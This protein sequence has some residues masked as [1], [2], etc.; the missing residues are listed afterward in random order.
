MRAEILSSCFLIILSLHIIS[1]S[2][3]VSQ[4]TWALFKT[5][6]RIVII[7]CR[8]TLN[9]LT[10]AKLH[11]F[12][13]AQHAYLTLHTNISISRESTHGINFTTSIMGP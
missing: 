4:L 5:S 1:Q 11:L 7:L 8:Q 6:K 9:K 10:K 13:K 12:L 2:D 3:S